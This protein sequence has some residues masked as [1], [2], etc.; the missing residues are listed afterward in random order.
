VLE[1]A[2]QDKEAKERLEMLFDQSQIRDRVREMAR[3]ISEDYR[4]TQPILVGVLKGSFM[5]VADLVRELEIDAVVDFIAVG[6]YGSSSVSSGAVRL[7][8][9]LNHD[10]RD[11]DVLFVEDIVDSGHTLSYIYQNFEARSPRSLEVV[12]LLD[13]KERREVD[14]CIR[15]V[16]FE[17][18][19]CFVV[20]YGLDYD[21]KYRGLPYLAVLKDH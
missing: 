8:K 9:D 19:N 4:D 5:F 7:L 14:I 10:I 2:L 3:K 11:R 21:E 1:R 17:I 6:S 20:G 16:G 18:P 15:Y 12:S 13:K